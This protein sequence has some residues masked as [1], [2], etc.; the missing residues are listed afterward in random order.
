M[1]CSRP[2][3]R[4][5]TTAPTVTS[6]TPA[7]GAG[8]V[9]AGTDVS[10]T[11]SEPVTEASIQ[12]SVAP[13]GGA[14]VDAATSYDA[15]S[16]TVTLTPSVVLSAGTEYTVSLGGAADPSGNVLTTTSWTFTTAASDATAPTIVST[17]P[18]DSATG[19]SRTADVSVMFDEPVVESTIQI[20][21]APSG[22]ADVDAATSYDAGTRTVTLDP[23][24]ALSYSTDYTVS[25]SGAADVAGN[26]MAPVSWTF[27]TRDEPAPSGCPCSIWSPSDEPD[28]TDSDTNSVEIGVKFRAAESGTVTGIRFFK[29]AI[30]TGVH[31]GSLWTASGTNLGSVTFT[32]ESATG[33]Q[34]ADFATPIQIEADTTYVVSYFAPNGRYSVLSND[35]R[36]FGRD[37][38][39]VD[40]AA[41]RGRR[42]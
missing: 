17:S 12:I 39:S 31:V 2:V 33:W 29:S 4:P 40:S 13:T 16:N 28:R 20:A 38:W 3:L 35:V 9:S 42:R 21:V 23:S 19:V 15:G 18:V 14:D 5:D 8:A 32:N 41:D 36:G 34:Q 26:V 6:Q 25:V 22:G 7:S 30:N 10:A 24:A 1:W 37:Q 27:T 11:F